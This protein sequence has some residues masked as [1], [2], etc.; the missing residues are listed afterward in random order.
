MEN[1][2]GIDS[3]LEDTQSVETQLTSPETEAATLQ[4]MSTPASIIPDYGSRPQT[5]VP[6]RRTIDPLD[7]AIAKANMD[8]QK[9]ISNPTTPT[10]YD[11]E[12]KERY[13]GD[14]SIYH[15]HFNP[16]TDYEKVA[17]DNWD[18][19]DAISTGLSRF[20]DSFSSS[21]KEYFRYD[22]LGKALYHLDLDY[23][24]PD[25]NDLDRMAYEQHQSEL[26]NPIYYAP[27]TEN[28]FLTKGFLAES[29]GSLGFTLGTLGGVATEQL[30]FKAAEVGLA[31]T[32][33][34]AAA[35]P[36]LEI[37][38]DVKAA[39]G[40][41][42]VWKSITSIFTGKAMNSA[43]FL[44]QETRTTANALR[45]GK[46]LSTVDDVIKTT[47]QESNVSM[48]PERYGT[49]FWNNAL[50]LATNVPFAGELADAVRVARAGQGV[51]TTAEL[52]KIGM[53]GLRRG[54]GEWQL[55]AGEAATEAGGNYYDLFEQLKDEYKKSHGG[56][57]AIGQDLLDLK[58]MALKSAGQDFGANVAILG[59]MNKVQWGNV[60]G[61][62]GTESAAITKIR[63]S[64]GT[65]AAQLGITAVEGIGKKTGKELT[66]LYQKGMFGTLGLLP[67]ISETFGRKK[68]AWELGK[69]MV[70]GLTKIELTEGIQ[71]NLQ[72]IATSG[73]TKHYVDM[74]KKNPTTWGDN[75]H[76]ALNEQISKKGLKTFASGALTGVFLSPTMHIIESTSK[77]FDKNAKAHR[78]AVAQSID[79][80]NKIYNGDSKNI[81]KE[82][83]KQIKLQTMYN[84]GMKEGLKTGDIYQYNNNKDSAFI[85]AIMYA[86][87]T[88][89]LDYFTSFLKG[90][91]KMSNEEFK[92][93]FNYSPEELGKS[94]SSEVTSDLAKSVTE[95]SDI[96]DHYQKKFGTF[97]QVQDYI[98][99][100]LAKQKYS[101][102]V[103]AL[104]D[105]ISTAAFIHSKSNATIKRQAGIREK[106]NQYDSIGQSLAGGF[107]TLVSPEKMDDQLLLVKNEIRALKQ[108]NTSEL[109]DEERERT[110]KQIN[111]KQRELDVLTKIKKVAY[112]LEEIPDPTNPEKT[113]R[114]YK[115]NGFDSS[116]ESFESVA[117]LMGEYL[118]IRNNR[119]GIE[120][121]VNIVEIREAMAD[122]HDYMSLGQDHQ[123]YVE[124]LNMLND[125]ETFGNYQ[126]RLMD[127]RVAAHANS[128]Y[129]EFQDL[130]EMSSVAKKFIEDNKDIFDKLVEFS[131]RPSGTYQN[132]YELKQI[133]DKLLELSKSVLLEKQQEALDEFQR[134][135]REE[136]QAKEEELKKEAELSK[137][138][139]SKLAKPLNS[140]LEQALEENDEALHSE[141]NEYFKMRYNLEDLEKFPFDE[142][143]PAKRLVYRYYVDNDGNQILLSDKPIMIPVEFHG[144]EINNL[145]NLYSYLYAFEE[146]VYNKQQAQQ[147]A[148][149]ITEAQASET[150]EKIDEAKTDLANHVGNPVMLGGEKGTLEVQD[151]AYVV[152]FPDGTTTKLSDIKE[153]E[154]YNLEDFTELSLAHESLNEETKAEVSPTTNPAVMDTTVDGTIRVELD[155]NFLEEVTINGIKWR[156]EKDENGF[157]IGFVN[158]FVRKKGKKQKTFIRRLSI[159]DKKGPGI[160]Y[161]AAINKLIMAMKELPEDA[162]ELVE[163]SEALDGA[164]NEA[165]RI[166]FDE[167]SAKRRS[168]ELILQY[169]VNKLLN[170]DIPDDILEIKAKFDHPFKRNQLSNNDLMKLF[171]WADDLDKKIIK[172]FRLQLTHPFVSVARASLNKDYINPI[173]EK[174]NA[175][176]SKRGSK[177]ASKRATT[178]SIKEKKSTSKLIEELKSPES[179]RGAAKTG[180][181]PKKQ[182]AGKGT[183]KSA[184]EVIQSEIAFPE[185]EINVEETASVSTTHELP[186]LDGAQ[187]IN[188]ISAERL[189]QIISLVDP[190]ATPR[191]DQPTESINL[192]N[193]FS[194][195]LNNLSCES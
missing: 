31:A 164:I 21:F 178:T 75:F 76:D 194:P 56:E 5:A 185:E 116:H 193:P 118:Q 124:S 19:W 50:K 106:L 63:M 102:Q 107:N 52:F 68:A 74:Y 157:V 83:I 190:S 41:S 110:L 155:E 70:K 61:K 192:E 122:I 146:A 11:P 115:T 51:L 134:I 88:G 77:A 45:E 129:D 187:R 96:Y 140:M 79:Y 171:M 26:R 170:D 126:M 136:Q 25:E 57:D 149:K 38:G 98:G 16:N 35:V 144:L 162:N 59:I 7:A 176:E 120:T 121:K 97:L 3:N 24:A 100:P 58:N 65:E 44:A 78:E 12:Q 173:S 195:L 150:V 80:L 49:K 69:S 159:K 156:L 128:L 27:G 18:K 95:Y 127:A 130:A 111:E 179:K 148:A 8:T 23:L 32:G 105:A 154:T 113:I 161:A 14:E 138:R 168:D 48:N 34:G 39:S 67:K 101:V 37:A 30:G 177:Q 53:G 153:G 186:A 93:A 47:I 135:K 191:V 72:D 46:A 133:N 87:R 84:D 141:I 43:E 10:Y 90:Y 123:E 167:T 6:A 89:T 13:K 60:F 82:Q 22:R 36:E 33:F 15:D 94:S 112:S 71:E 174:I 166:M 109:T 160:K 169:Q 29:I 165:Q 180:A 92:E 181:K 17:Y 86:K 152:K 66:Q 1:I 62:F 114:V 81:L 9:A 158:E 108:S 117:E 4:E 28:D 188:T 182:K 142:T 137:L 99:D 42:K 20:K 175:R 2:L 125:P 64:L 163:E 91:G 143:D 183:V 131:K 139:Q 55:A 151:N 104:L 85:Q 145:D 184:V 132:M 103:G 172:K 189:N 40:L 73:L 147:A 119:A 54:I